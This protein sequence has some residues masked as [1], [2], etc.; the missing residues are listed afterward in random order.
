MRC[1]VSSQQ[2]FF[3][4]HDLIIGKRG[5]S[6]SRIQETLICKRG[7]SRYPDST[8]IWASLQVQRS[9]CEYNKCSSQQYNIMFALS[10]NYYLYIQKIFT[11]ACQPL[12]TTSAKRSLALQAQISPHILQ[13]LPDATFWSKW[14]TTQAIFYLSVLH[15]PWRVLLRSSIG[16]D[17]SKGSLSKDYSYIERRDAWWRLVDMVDMRQIMN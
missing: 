17:K 1:Y 5:S 4:L 11:G 6:W 3:K 13:I 16:F 10:G 14:N 8:S 9:K 7:S 15:V 2:S 12:H